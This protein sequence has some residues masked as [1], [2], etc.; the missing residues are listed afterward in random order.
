MSTIEIVYAGRRVNQELFY[1]V[2]SQSI[3][4]PAD[5]L[6]NMLT[7]K[8]SKTIKGYRIG[9]IYE[10]EHDESTYRFGTTVWQREFTDTNLV[11]IWQAAYQADRSLAQAKAI[12]RREATN[13]SALLH[14]VDVLRTAY[15]TLAPSQRLGFETWIL[16][17]LRG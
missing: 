4:E 13:D 16:N 3:L 5:S 12:E 8:K 7:F 17:K 2:E 1:V 6:G 11:R 10:I 15:R 9:H 14:N